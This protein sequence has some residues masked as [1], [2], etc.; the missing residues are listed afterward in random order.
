M[1]QRCTDVAPRYPEEDQ[2]QRRGCSPPR[3]SAFLCVP[4]CYQRFGLDAL[5]ARRDR[6]TEDREEPGGFSQES[7]RPSPALAR[8]GR[9]IS[10]LLRILRHLRVRRSRRQFAPRS[11][12]APTARAPLPALVSNL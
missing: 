1:T 2:E 6:T 4:L 3:P 5:R 10:A 12:W 9:S 8:G 11:R 7:L